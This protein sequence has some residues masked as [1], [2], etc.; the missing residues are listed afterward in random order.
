MKKNYQTFARAVWLSMAVCLIALSAFSQNGTIKG[1]ITDA[2]GGGIPGA[3]IKIKG[4]NLGTSTDADGK[5]AIV[6]KAGDV[7]VI[8][9]TGF[10]KKEI[11]IGKSTTLNIKLQDAEEHLDEVI[12][13]GYGT[14]RRS[15]ITGSVSKLDPKVLETGVRSNPASAL[16]GTIPGL[17]VQQTSGRPGA[18]P[19]IILRGGTEYDGSGSPLILVD[20]LVRDGFD[21]INQDDIE[22]MEVLKDASS[23]AIYGARANNGVILITTKK[24]KVGQSQISIKSKTGINKLNVPFDFLNARDYLYWSRTAVKN[25]G[26]YDAGRLTQLTSVGPFGTGNLFKDGAGNILDGNKTANAVW[27]TMKLDNNNR[28]KLQDGWQTMIDPINGTDTLI[29]NDFDYGAYALKDYSLTQDYNAS[30]NGGNEK[31]KYYAGLGYYTEDGMPINT[32][33]NRLTFLVNGEYKVKPWLTSNSSLNFADADWRDPINNE[34]NYVGRALGAPPTMRGFNENGDL[35]VGRDYQDGN[36]AVNDAKFIRKNNRTKTTYSQAFTV[37]FL[38][39]LSLRTSANWYYEQI[40]LERFD[41]DYL[42]SP[43][44]INTKRTTSASTA[45]DFNQTYNSV[46]NYNTTIFDKHHLDAMLGVEYKDKYSRGFSASGSGAPTDDFMDLDLALSDKSTGDTRAIS[47]GHSRQREMSL[48]SRINYDYDNRYLLTATLRRDGYS[49]LINNRWGSFP[50]I[51]IGWNIHKEDFMESLSNTINMLKLR[52]SYGKTGNVDPKGNYVTSYSLQG[53]YGSFKYNGIIGNNLST[54]P[55]PDLR[56]ESSSTYEAGLDGL[57]INKIDF[58]LSFY[59]RRTEDKIAALLP[60]ISAGVPGGAF[61]TNNGTME[62]KGV[63]LGLNY[64]AYTTKDWQI[65][66]SASFAYNANKIIKLPYNGL[67]KNRQNAFQV[68]DPN[69]KELIWVGGNQ[70]GEDPN[71]AYSYYA[72]DLYRTQA[73][74]DKY[75]AN[76]TD[77]NPG[78]KVLVGSA[79]Y[80]NMTPAQRTAV[81]QIALG[82]VRWRDVNGDNI[83]NSYDRVKMGRTV[84]PWTGGFGINAKWKNLAL[85]TRFDYAL[86][87]VQYDG[88][89]SW[90]LGNAQ[91]TFNTTTDVF[92]TWTPQN[93]N[94]KYPTYYWADQLFKNN[95]FR[96]SS[97]FV[98]KG[99]YLALREINLT[100]SLPDKIATK[101]KSQGVNFSVT[102]ENLTYFSKSTLFSPEANSIGVGGSS[103]YPLPLTLIFG[104]QFIF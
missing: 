23:T 44:S 11:T 36:P 28:V 86:G 74:L 65:D 9:S 60:P 12:V 39:N 13:V 83:I 42:Q 87:F 49:K 56:W 37:N 94:A 51:S 22:S 84:P 82:D 96:N 89:N 95:T 71:V 14:Q 102:G 97:M 32:F 70:E 62:N 7:L 41:R 90:F 33:Y 20:G 10:A 58:T 17:R 93:P 50:G 15:K 59:R 80:A 1:T 100:Y 6:A 104:V 76:L 52:L 43:G 75:A 34:G 53:L 24:G 3:A 91:G 79:V 78:S 63:E 25:S 64:R 5:F 8:S 4:T 46:L 68:Y 31:G 29:F 55:F 16:A 19:N 88:V 30:V 27:S 67:E 99:D 72:E 92:D 47:S 103:G 38:K 35:L 26:V 69:T 45:R 98:H 81:Y 73:D 77:V 66:F 57:L 40:Y 61:V 101:L 85:R 2:T 18:T 48:F 54:M 21:D